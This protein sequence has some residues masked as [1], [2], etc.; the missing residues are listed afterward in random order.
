MKRSRRYALA[1]AAAAAAVLVSAPGMAQIPGVAP[2]ISP[3]PGVAAGIKAPDLV[4]TLGPGSPFPSA[5]TVKNQGNAD[6]G[7]SLLKVT[8]TLLPLEGLPT[9]GCPAILSSFCELQSQAM[10]ASF[11]PE[12]LRSLCG[13]PFADILDAIGPLKAGE[14]KT[15]SRDTSRFGHLSLK[16]GSALGAQPGTHI[17]VGVTTLVCA[18]DVVAQADA[19]NQVGE[20]REDN[21]TAKLR[22][23]REIRLE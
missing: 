1:A 19:S 5:F 9:A 20:L 3:I 15:V 2:R 16:L 13:D 17:K 23:F 4:V 8:A 22:V 10:A 21:N 6:A 14:S 18:F 12:R 11:T 7:A